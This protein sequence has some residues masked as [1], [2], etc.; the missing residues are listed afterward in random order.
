MYLEFGG[1]IDSR[2]TGQKYLQEVGGPPIHPFSA[3]ITHYGS[4]YYAV[5][6]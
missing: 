6:I 4:Y 5:K 1:T 2:P 3:I